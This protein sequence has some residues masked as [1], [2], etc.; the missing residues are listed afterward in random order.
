[1]QNR[2]NLQIQ[3]VSAVLNNMSTPARKEVL[4]ALET[5]MEAS[6]AVKTGKASNGKPVAG[7]RIRREEMLISKVI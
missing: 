7:S 5:L 6:A 3:N 4:T 2:E 1:M